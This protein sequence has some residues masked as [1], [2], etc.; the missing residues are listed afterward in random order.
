[1]RR[2][3]Q[4]SGGESSTRG[5]SQAQQARAPEGSRSRRGGGAEGEEEQEGRRSRRKTEACALRQG[6]QH[7]LLWRLANAGLDSSVRTAVSSFASGGLNMT[8]PLTEEL[9]QPK[10]WSSSGTT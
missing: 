10:P 7:M 8:R 4:R 1:M 2:R 3:E 5:A 6:R 9:E